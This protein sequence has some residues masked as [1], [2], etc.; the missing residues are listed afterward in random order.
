LI[1]IGNNPPIETGTENTWDPRALA[2]WYGRC[3][4]LSALLSAALADA[5]VWKSSLTSW[6]STKGDDERFHTAML[7]TL[8]AIQQCLGCP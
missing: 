2:N 6:D 4:W 1:K 8:D 7:G 3:A 5:N